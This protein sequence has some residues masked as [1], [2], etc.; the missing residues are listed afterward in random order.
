LNPGLCSD[1]PWTKCLRYGM[2]DLWQENTSP[3]TAIMNWT[4][5]LRSREV[6]VKASRREKWYGSHFKAA[7][8]YVA[9]QYNKT[10]QHDSTHKIAL[11]VFIRNTQSGESYS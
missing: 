3:V 5:H 2:A 8:A 4:P 1:K 9:G 7:I 10:A 6:N 11:T